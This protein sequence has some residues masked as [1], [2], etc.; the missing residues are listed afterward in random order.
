[1]VKEI[2]TSGTLIINDIKL[3]GL[4]LNWL[5]LECI[6]SNLTHNHASHFCNST[7]VSGWTFKLL[8]GSELEAGNLFCFLRMRIHATKASHLT[9]TSIAGKR[10][11]YGRHRLLCLSKLKSFISNNNL[12]SYFR[13]HF[14]LPQGHF[15]TEFTLPIKWTQQV[16]L[17]MHGEQLNLG[18]LLSAPRITKN[19]GMHGNAMPPHETSTLS[20]KTVKNRHNH[21]SHIFCCTG[22]VKIKV[23]TIVKALLAISTSI[24]LV[25]K[26]CSFKKKEDDYILPV[27]HLIEG[28]RHKD[29]PPTP[30]LALPISVPNDCCAR[31]LMTESPCMQVTWD[32]ILI[33]FYYLLRCVKNT[34]PRYV[35]QRD[36]SIKQ[37]MHTKQF[38]V[39][40][41][42]FW[43][44]GFQI[45]HNSCYF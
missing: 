5:A 44:G 41:V 35:C 17:C 11:L 36:G 27:K 20:S 13:N 32:L 33:A 22:P 6:T 29:P 40:D 18:S 4:V 1:M 26:S 38:T 30:Q 28:I 16:M 39:S 9:P 24:H 45:P 15:S 12:T 31:G 21:C 19:I 23:Q 14:P 25:G 43:K 37:A 34:A 42:G 2:F 8:S 7:S 3:A 10:K